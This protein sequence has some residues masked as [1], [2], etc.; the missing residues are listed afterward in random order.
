MDHIKAIFFDLDGTLR[1]NQPSGD[2]VFNDYLLELGLMI[3]G[4]DMTRA[5]RWEHYYFANS[6]EI[7]ADQNQHVE[8]QAFWLNFAR[9]R[10]VALGCHP[11]QAHSLAPKVSAYMNEHY[12]PRTHVPQEVFPLLASIKERGY[13]LGV[14]SNREG[15]FYEELKELELDG[16]FRFALAGGEVDA[17]K[18][19]PRIF[20]HA[21]ERAGTSAA[22]TIYVGDNYFADILGSSRA[23][24]VPVLFDPAGLFPEADCAV[25]RSFH[26]FPALLT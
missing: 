19:D 1:H 22:E 15:P 9:R 25:I 16:Y 11:Q 14:V 7:R 26:E 10:L 13:V 3:S 23:G 18:P 2:Q 6:P 5:Q 17:F 12:K 20:E 24:L 21:L 8:P 4:E